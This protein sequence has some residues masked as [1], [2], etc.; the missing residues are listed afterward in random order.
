MFAENDT[1]YVALY[2]AAANPTKYA[3][4]GFHRRVVSGDAGAVGAE[5]GTK[6][7]ALFDVVIA[8]GAQYEIQIR[9]CKGGCA[10]PFDSFADIFAARIGEADEFYRAVQVNRVTD[11]LL[12][13]RVCVVAL[14]RS[15]GSVRLVQ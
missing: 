6:A 3:K 8:P 4:D 14:T 15:L 7:A 5:S 1:N 12:L 2:G 11:R 10:A 13:Q 9:L